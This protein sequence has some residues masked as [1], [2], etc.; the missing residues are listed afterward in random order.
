MTTDAE[1]LLEDLKHEAIKM[2]A[3]FK[4]VDSSTFLFKKES[5]TE[6]FH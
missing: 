5:S 4:M 6:A 2:D 1:K 3:W